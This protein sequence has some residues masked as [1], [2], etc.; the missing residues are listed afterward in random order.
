ML[1]LAGFCQ[2]SLPYIS[3]LKVINEATGYLIFNTMHP[4]F[5]V[6]K[7]IQFRHMIAMLETRYATRQHF[8]EMCVHTLYKKPTT[9]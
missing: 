3:H 1:A 8:T 6:T 7:K 4:Y 2:S 5:S 9:I